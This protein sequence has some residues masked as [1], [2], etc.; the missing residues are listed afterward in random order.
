[1]AV[2]ENFRGD[3]PDGLAGSQDG[4]P[5]GVLP[6]HGLHQVLKNH[7]VRGI[8][9]H[10]DL[11]VDDSPLLFHAFGG[12]IGGG[13][14]FQQQ[15]QTGIEILRAGEIIGGHVVAGEGVGAGAQPGKFRGNVPVGQVEHLVL[16]VVGN[17]RRRPVILPGKPVVRMH[18]AIVRHKIG[19]APGK[20]L[21]GH[22][23][24]R[25][26]VGKLLA[27]QRLVQLRVFIG[28]HRLSPFRK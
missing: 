2:V 12:E 13:H 22:H 21:P 6:V 23:A 20:A 14:E 28:G 7:A 10:A 27:V 15:T 5:D 18:G 19:Q 11:L 4:H 26:P 17:P 25:Q 8:L 24:H 16:Q 9:V 3:F 1:M